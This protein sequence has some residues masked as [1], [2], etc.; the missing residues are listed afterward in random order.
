MRQIGDDP[1]SRLILTKKAIKKLLG[2]TRYWRVSAELLRGRE[3]RSGNVPIRKQID[4]SYTLG[5]LR[6]LIVESL[7]VPDRNMAAK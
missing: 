5:T 2:L 3:V 6:Q 7:A 1:L 4:I